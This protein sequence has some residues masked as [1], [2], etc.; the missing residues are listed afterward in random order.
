ML[1]NSG[2]LDQTPRSGA[3][4]LGRHC[5]SLSIK[6]DG[7]FTWVNKKRFIQNSLTSEITYTC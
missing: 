5:L 7:R 2:D 4:D 1:A 6:K 3:S